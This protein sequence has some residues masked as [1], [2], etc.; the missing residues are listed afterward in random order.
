MCSNL[1]KSKRVL[2]LSGM[3]LAICLLG[4]GCI[5]QKIVVK[6]RPDGTGQIMVSMIYS[7][8]MVAMQEAQ[9]QQVKQ[10]M[11]ESGGDS[12]VTNNPYYNPRLLRYMGRQF[13]SDVALSKSRAYDKKGDRGFLALYEFKDINELQVDTQMSMSAMA[14]SQMSMSMGSSGLD[15]DAL[16]EQMDEQ[17]DQM[18]AQMG[19]EDGGMVKFKLTQGDKSQLD[20][21]LP[22][23]DSPFEADDVDLEDEVPTA[24]STASSAQMMSMGGNPFGFTGQETETQ[25]M[26]KMMAG[27]SL[28]LDVEVLADAAAAKNATSH[29]SKKNRWIVYNMDFGKI[30]AD[31]RGSGA[32][33][34]M[35]EN[36]Y[37]GAGMQLSSFGQFLGLPGAQV[38]TNSFSITF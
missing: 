33:K 28:S 21:I 15:E 14:M 6:V 17:M 2:S 32:M 7:Q 27:M 10:M 18:M 26:Q 13:G 8:K 5:K 22:S 11:A 24:N 12:A 4:S 20:V 34:A 9:M 3:L 35:Q 31:K 23:M 36:A 37:T 29:P 38:Q 25:M 1:F 30:V 19:G 16:D